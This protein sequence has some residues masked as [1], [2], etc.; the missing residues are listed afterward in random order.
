MT[1]GPT[2]VLHT[3]R[4]GQLRG[5]LQGSIPEQQKL[6]IE[7]QTFQ[8]SLWRSEPYANIDAK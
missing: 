2:S 8:P 5:S 3:L 1:H 6:K 4:P 7:S